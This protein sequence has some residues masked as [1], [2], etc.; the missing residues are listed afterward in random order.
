MD[1]VVRVEAH[2]SP[3][4]TVLGEDVRTFPGGKGANQAAAAARVGDAVRMLGRVGTDGYG[5]ELKDALTEAGVETRY[6]LEQPGPTGMAFITV[7]TAGQ[8]MIVVSSGANR[9]LSPEDVTTAL[10]DGVGIVLMQLEC[11]LEAVQRVAELAEQLG[12]PVMLN[13]APGRQLEDSLLKRLTYLVV[14]ESEA[15]L[16]CGQAVSDVTS[17]GVAAGLLSARGTSHVIVTLGDRGVVWEG[18]GSR[19]Q[20]PA[21]QVEVV[22]TTAAGDAFCGALAVRL[23][24]GEKLEEAL[25]FANAAGALATT[26]VGA[27]PSLPKRNDVE[28]MM[29]R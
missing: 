10:F 8:N 6:I 7:D 16:L 21:H 19:G 11:P 15:T 1:L 22:D 17:A 4:E 20:L 23:A 13:A 29:G 5:Q 2:P 24:E 3:G 28:R 14:N 27:Q 9:H 25:R 18:T 12:V 26:K